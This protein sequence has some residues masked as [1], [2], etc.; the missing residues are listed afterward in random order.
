MLVSPEGLALPL[1][2]PGSVTAEGMDLVPTQDSYILLN[3]SRKMLSIALEIV[4]ICFVC[5]ADSDLAT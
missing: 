1:G 5:L 3:M 4:T 2:N